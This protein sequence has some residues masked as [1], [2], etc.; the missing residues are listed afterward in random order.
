MLAGIT[1]KAL[2]S[3]G[4]ECNNQDYTCHKVESALVS[5]PLCL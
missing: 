1:H 5:Y 2:D 3:Y 4:L